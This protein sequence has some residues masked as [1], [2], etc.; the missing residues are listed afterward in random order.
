MHFFA[1]SPVLHP[2]QSL[3]YVY[4]VWRRPLTLS[5][6]T[7]V[8]ERERKV[9]FSCAARRTEMGLGVTGRAPPRPPPHP[10]FWR[11]FVLSPGRPRFECVS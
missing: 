8:W 2:C 7:R 4:L 5:V 9:F 3:P 10:L 11:I 1:P 6:N